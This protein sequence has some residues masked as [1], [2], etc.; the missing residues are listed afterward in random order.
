MKREGGRKI[1]GRIEKR[2]R[3]KEGLVRAGDKDRRDAWKDDEQV[4]M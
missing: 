3:K 4:V 1:S 2:M